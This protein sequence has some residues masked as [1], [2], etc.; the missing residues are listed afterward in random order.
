MAINATAPHRCALMVLVA[1]MPRS[2]STWQFHMIKRALELM[3]RR[4]SH[5]GYWDL[6]K[7]K[8]M[9]ETAAAAYYAR[10]RAL[11][12]RLAEPAVVVYKSHEFV[13]EATRFCRHTAV[14]TTHR[15]F[16]AALRS[17]IG[18]GWITAEAAA[19]P[20]YL[21]RVMRRD[22]VEFEQ[23]KRLGA[24]DFDYDE[25]ARYPEE[26][27]AAIMHFL[28]LHL[29][30]AGDAH[31][32]LPALRRRPV[33]AAKY[34]QTSQSGRSTGGLAHLTPKIM[35]AMRDA[36]EM[37]SKDDSLARLGVRW[38]GTETMQLPAAGPRKGPGRAAYL[39]RASQP[40]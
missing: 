7:H 30:A 20:G 11:W 22:L 16:E 26:S 38:C 34:V 8:R 17:Q 32:V 21:V 40:G 35:Q 3:G 28:A 15:C 12:S 1:G 25:A 31:S 29:R 14:L 19:D 33:H 6:A 24:L 27:M 37:M 36:R 39:R 10:E 4:A 5:S 23:W 18:R 9:N 13:P 2:G